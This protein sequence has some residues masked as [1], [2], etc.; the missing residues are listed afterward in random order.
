MIG[1]PDR[2][3]TS[4]APVADN[5]IGLFSV[6]GQDGYLREVNE[7]F[8]GLLGLTPAEL[9]DRSILE[10]VHPDDIASIVAGMA[11]LAGGA[12]EVQLNSRFFN[13][14]GHLVYL[15]WVARPIPGTHLWSAAGRDNTA[16]HKLVADQIDLKARLELAVG[17]VTAAMWDLDLRTATFSW[18]SQ[19]TEVLGVPSG[20]L[21]RTP[22]E[23]G[24]ITHPDDR[25]ALDQAFVQ[26]SKD[27]ATE[28][29]LRIGTGPTQRHLSIRGKVQDRDRRGRPLRAVGLALDITVQKAMEEQMFRMVMSDALTGVPNRRAFEQSLR[30]EFR[31]CTRALVPLSVAI[32]DIDDFKAVNDTLGHLVG[33]DVLC[34]IARSMTAVLQR[35]GDLLARFGGEE[36]AVVLPGAAGDA[37]QQIASQLLDV[38]RGTTLRQAVGWNFSVSV[39]TAT[40]LPGEEKIK[41]NE[42]LSRADEALYAA[43][44]AGKNRAL[45]YRCSE[46]A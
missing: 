15:R 23:F 27:G 28:V 35:E 42:L 38:V 26:L 3:V 16:F 19:A 31:R 20:E 21:P 10:L 11:E 4:A 1:S 36:F 13:H 2:P 41:P 7:A 25:E 32:I 46:A 17:Q 5:E 45:A 44:R 18:E 29:G 8:A 12:S 33:D 6:A 14:A 30:T 24:A 22:G 37:A 9:N 43:K 39:G 40:W 34:A